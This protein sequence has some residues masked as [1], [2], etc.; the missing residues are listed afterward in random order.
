M[1]ANKDRNPLDNM[2]ELVFS[3]TIDYVDVLAA[4]SDR[5]HSQIDSS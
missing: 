2:I 5:G 1:E 3:S 4:W